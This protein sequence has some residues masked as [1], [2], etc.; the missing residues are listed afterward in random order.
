VHAEHLTEFETDLRTS[1]A[2]VAAA[3]ATGEQGAYGSIE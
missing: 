2:E 3:G 1:V